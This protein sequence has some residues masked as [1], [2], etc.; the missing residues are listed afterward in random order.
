MVQQAGS[1]Q[2]I[3]VDYSDVVLGFMMITLSV[4][5]FLG[6]DRFA[7]AIFRWYHKIPEGKSGPRWVRW[8]FRPTTEQSRAIARAAPLIGLFIGIVKLAAGLGLL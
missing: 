3:S 2:A 1:I 4:W 8:Q 7:N 5:T 6:R